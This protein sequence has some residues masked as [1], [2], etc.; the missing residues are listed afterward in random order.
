MRDKIESFFVKAN[1]FIFEFNEKELAALDITKKS[2]TEFHLIK[3]Y[4]SITGRVVDSDSSGKKLLVEVEG[5]TFDIEIKTAL[6]AMLE[7]MGFNLTGSKRLQDVKAPMPGLVLKT[8]VTEG[9]QL[10][11][12]DAVLILE[13]MKM[14][15]CILLHTDARIKKILVKN[16][17]V[18]EKGQVLV[19]LE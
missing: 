9:Q 13:A 10:K 16:G 3:N 19:E 6:D 12:G 17:Q 1:E 5:N 11:E 8:F 4:K 18:V 2:D 14:E 7:K 15:N